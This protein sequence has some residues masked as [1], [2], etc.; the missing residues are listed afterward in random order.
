[1]LIEFR[2]NKYFKEV[3]VAP[4]EERENRPTPGLRKS[5]YT[6]TVLARK[7]LVLHALEES[8][9]ATQ[10]LAVEAAKIKQLLEWG[11]PFHNM[12]KSQSMIAEVPAK[13]LLTRAAELLGQIEVP[14]ELWGTCPDEGT[15]YVHKGIRGWY[16]GHT[17]ALW[18]NATYPIGNFRATTWPATEKQLS[19]STLALIETALCQVM[20]TPD[21]R[22][23]INETNP[24]LS[25]SKT[26]TPEPQ[27]EFSLEDLKRKFSK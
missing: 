25:V 15:V 10:A 1:M 3:F 14:E 24:A 12:L 2:V 17:V 9:E 26:S 4:F 22:Y 13:S 7:T 18:A 16:M 21:S 5:G 8:K 27:E 23:A 20:G 11:T 19:A 6:E